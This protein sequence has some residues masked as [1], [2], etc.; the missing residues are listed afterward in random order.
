MLIHKDQRGFTLIELIVAIAITGLITGGITTAIF[1]VFNVNTLSNN[2]ML[3]LRQVQNAG[4]WISHDAQMAQATDAD[5]VII[6]EGHP[7]YDQAEGQTQVLALVW[8]GWER[9]EGTGGNIRTCIDTYEVRYTYDAGSYKLWRHQKITTEKYD[10][11]GQ[12]IETT[13]T[14]EEGWNTAFVAGYIYLPLEEI[15][16]GVYMYI[17]G[18][19]DGDKLVVT[20]TARVGGDYW[21]AEET[22]TYEIMPRP[23]S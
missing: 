12:W 3:A 2:H 22:R 1:Q 23:G 20:I 17:V 19:M 18:Y 5:P 21:P 9:T 16:E 13:Y 10:K 11:N 14:P 15:E 4:Y 7:L 6:D 8:V